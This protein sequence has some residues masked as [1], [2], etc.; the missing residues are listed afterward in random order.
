[1]LGLKCLSLGSRGRTQTLRGHRA[2]TL[3]RSQPSLWAREAWGL[4]TSGF[5]RTGE[6]KS[7][8]LGLE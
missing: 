7:Q 8:L 4:R 1:M 2:R 6:S 5:S 3:R